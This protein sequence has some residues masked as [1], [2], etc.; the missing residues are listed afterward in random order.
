MMRRLL[1]KLRNR[2]TD[3][4]TEVKVAIPDDEW[5]ELQAFAAEAD[6]LLTCRTVQNGIDFRVTFGWDR[7]SRNLACTGQMPP[8]DD[9]A[10]LLH[11]LRPFVLQREVGYFYR[12]CNILARRMQDPGL[13]ALIDSRRT[14]FS[15]R[16]FQDHLRISVSN[17]EMETVVNGDDT[18]MKWLNAFEYHRD[19]DKNREVEEL[20]KM[21]PSPALRAVFVSM[22]IDK[23][24]A[25]GDV[26]TL[27]GHCETADGTTL[28]V[29]G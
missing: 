19:T 15:G 18:L 17:G 27:V 8:D 11:R 12:V 6:R 13:R 23:I 7:E 28:H 3:E 4:T 20:H 24:K 5:G 16:D 22:V 9:V 21:L 2:D 10:V 14:L 26:R 1:V 25:V 29:G